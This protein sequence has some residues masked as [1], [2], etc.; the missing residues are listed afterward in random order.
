MKFHKIII[1]FVTYISVI[2]I[3][4][5]PIVNAQNENGRG[6]GQGNNSEN[7]CERVRNK[8]NSKIE[9]YRNN[10]DKHLERYNKIYEKLQTLATRLESSGYDVSKLEQYLE[11]LKL[12]ITEF[13]NNNEN[14]FHELTNSGEMACEGSRQLFDNSISAA[15]ENLRKVRE[16]AKNIKDFI[17]STIKPELQNIKDQITSE[18]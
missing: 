16:S 11:Q 14:S 7:R 17:V 18:N 4:A 6:N 3:V 2:L 13:N 5:A 10:R 15:R 9:H 1:F 8:V 12:M